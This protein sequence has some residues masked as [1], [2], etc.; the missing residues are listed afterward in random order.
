MKIMKYLSIGEAAILLG[1]AV[2]TLRRWER[3]AR[4]APCFRTAGGHRRYALH[5]IQSLISPFPIICKTL[6]YAR[7][8]SHDQKAD[9][10][11]Q[12]ERLL[13]W[14]R[15]RGMTDVQLISDLGSGLN[16]RKKGLR[17]LLRLMVGR[18]FNHLVLTH[19]DRLLLF[20]SELIFEWCR[21]LKIQVSVIYEQESPD[22]T[23]E[24]QLATDVIE[25]M[26]VFS[27]RLYG[28]RSHKNRKT[29]TANRC[30]R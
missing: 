28:S 7:V 17:Q 29:N 20:G 11:R 21:L 30:L 13:L 2:S 19:K 26:T 9:L 10:E 14:C 3:E 25:L 15:E 27:A 8:S 6:C 24:I 4:L 16:Y 12:G 5:A 18:Q 23:P 1:V 22:Q